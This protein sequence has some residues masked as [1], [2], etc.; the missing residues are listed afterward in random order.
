V[1]KKVDTKLVSN[2]TDINLEK[3]KVLHEGPIEGEI[4]LP[5]LN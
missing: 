5:D 3:Y 4:L 2:E 1:P